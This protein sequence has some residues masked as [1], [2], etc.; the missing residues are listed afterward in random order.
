MPELTAAQIAAGAKNA[1]DLPASP[2]AKGR[3]RCV[4]C[5]RPRWR[6]GTLQ[7]A[8]DHYY[9]LHNTTQKEGTQ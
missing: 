7:D 5:R 3:W 9:T 4:L 6:K 2:A 8:M 1:R